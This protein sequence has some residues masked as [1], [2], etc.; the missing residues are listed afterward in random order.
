MIKKTLRLIEE[1]IGIQLKLCDYFTGLRETRGTGER[2]F[3]VVLDVRTSESREYTNL[4]QYSKKYGS[5]R[6][7][8]NG[9]KRVAIFP[10]GA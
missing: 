1:Q 2:Y 7:E 3:N 10:N 8:P 4:E 9:F 6:V 5:I